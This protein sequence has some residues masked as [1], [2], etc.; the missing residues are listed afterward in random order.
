MTIAFAPLIWVCR[1][2][3]ATSNRLNIVAAVYERRRIMFKSETH[4][5]PRRVISLAQPWVWPIIA[6]VN[7]WVRA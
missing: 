2:C 6:G 3:S 7:M 5:I 4:S 1:V